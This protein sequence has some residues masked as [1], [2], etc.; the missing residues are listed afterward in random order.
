MSC[1]SKPRGCLNKVDLLCTVYT[2]EKIPELNIYPGEDGQTV[3]QKIINKTKDTYVIEKTSELLNDGEDGENKFITLNDIPRVII[4]TKLSEFEND[5]GFIT[6]S[7]IPGVYI[8][9]NLSEFNNDEGFIT[10]ADLPPPVDISGK[11]DKSTTYTKTE[12]NNLVTPKANTTD[13][14]NALGLKLDKPTV[15]ASNTTTYTHAVLV[16]SNNNPAKYPAGDLGKNVANS[17]LTSVTGAKLTLGADWEINVGTGFYFGLKGLLDKSSD[18]TFN[19]MVVTDSSG[20]TAYTDPVSQEIYMST[21]MTDAQKLTWRQNMRLSTEAWS[22]G[23][24]EVLGVVLPFVDNT[25]TFQ[26]PITLLGNNLFI[27]NVTPNSNI[28][29]KRVKDINGNSLTNGEVYTISNYTVLKNFPNM[30]SIIDDWSKYPTG[31]YQFLIT[32]GTWTNVASSELLVTSNLN[33]V[34]IKYDWDTSKQAKATVDTDGAVIFSNASGNITSTSIITKEECQR[35]FMLMLRVTGHTA[36][37]GG[38]SVAPS[39]LI[40]LRDSGGTNHGVSITE[41]N[42][43]QF[44]KGGILQKT[45][46]ASISDTIIFSYK[47]GLLQI[48]SSNYNKSAVYSL[49]TFENSDKHLYITTTSGTGVGF[50]SSGNIHA[51]EKYVL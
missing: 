42:Q 14:N 39:T 2:G 44:S 31:Y 19:R 38:T 28:K 17:A 25:K 43:Y 29:L 33:G 23:V 22:V 21:Q 3:L 8:P 7:D 41:R 35:G 45:G 34:S 47:N 30:I 26:Q 40:T 16:D 24:P 5:E 20:R 18:T 6:L 36:V 48:I 51:F 1:N 15:T 11:A 13:V 9:T 12:V 49:P 32:H 27:D 4:P 46:G 10:E 50:S 37:G